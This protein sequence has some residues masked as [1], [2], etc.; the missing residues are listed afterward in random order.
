MIWP[1]MVGSVLV[2]SV[3]GKDIMRE[4]VEALRNFS[5]YHL[6]EGLEMASERGQ[7]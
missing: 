2:V 6:T 1:D 7:L 3:E 4:R 5:Q